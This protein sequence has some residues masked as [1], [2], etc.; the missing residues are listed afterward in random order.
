[1]YPVLFTIGDTPVHSYYLLW[2]LA[3]M[4]AVLLVRSRMTGMYGLVDDDAR[5]IIIWGFLGMLLGARMG[6]VYDS[7]AI[8]RADLWRILRVWEGGLS[9]I[10]AFLGAAALSLVAS[11]ARG[12]SF[13]KVVDAA[14]TPAALTVAVGRWGC[15]LNGCCWGIVTTSPLGV[16]FISDSPDV[17]RHPT[18]L[19]YS[20]G[21]LAIAGLLQWTEQA[22]LGDGDARRVKGAVLC[23]LFSV[24]YS[25]MRLSIDPFRSDYY[26]AGMQLNRYILSVTAVVG[27]AW[28][29]HSLFAKRGG[30]RGL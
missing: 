7:W 14:A 24:L 4:M 6:S 26:G 22:L 2:T 10:P 5:A 16:R 8:Y 9:A 17:L 13:W 27:A 11:L 19:Y 21:A 25:V 20:F 30:E 18:Q 23:P 29:A 3:L 12:V 1:M 28:L 15:F